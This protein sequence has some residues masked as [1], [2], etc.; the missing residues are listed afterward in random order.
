MT[1]DMKEV[2]R[3]FESVTGMRVAL[4]ER[5]GKAN[6]TLARS[7]PLKRQK[8][9][10]EDCFIFTTGKG[11]CE[12]NCVGYEV[13]CETCH[14]DGRKTVYEGETGKN[15]YTRGAEHQDSLR[16][17]DEENALWKHCMVEH[18]GVR[19]KF[20]MKVCGRFHS[21]LVRQVDE[22]VRIDSSKADCLMN[23]KTEFHQAPLVR[24]VPT[25]GLLDEQED[26]VQLRESRGRGRGLRDGGGIGGAVR[27]G[28]V[29]SRRLR[30]GAVKG[31]R[32]RGAEE[33]V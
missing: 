25:T 31:R 22:A 5:A 8:C 16:L 24:V 15:G 12:K 10:R 23:S 19:A 18:G 9:D 26:R 20:S 11:N 33:E 6:K 28:A 32:A 1:R 21:C 27:G 29:S 14:M 13:K 2:C 17:K 3:R 7:E 30:G 4:Q